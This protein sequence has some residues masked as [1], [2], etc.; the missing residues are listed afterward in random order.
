VKRPLPSVPAG[1]GTNGFHG[2]G[3]WQIL[4]D[5]HFIEFFSLLLEFERT[6]Y[7]DDWYK[8][9]TRGCIGLNN[10]RIGW[11]PARNALPQWPKPADAF[12]DIGKNDAVF[13]DEQSAKAY[14]DNI[15][16][17]NPNRKYVL[18]AAQVKLIPSGATDSFTNGPNDGSMKILPTFG[19]VGDEGGFNYATWFPMSNTLE[20]GYWEY[21]NHG[22]RDDATDPVTLIHDLLLPNL[23]TKIN[24]FVV[25]DV[26]NLPNF[27]PGRLGPSPVR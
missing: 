5:D 26:T 23:F 12:K 4:D 11:R 10:I 9:S 15:A 14:L 8:Q 18:M 24:V 2:V 25:K 7:P 1:T 27:P 22:C 17:A 16:A 6:N 19:V 3:Q 13:N 20:G 21:M